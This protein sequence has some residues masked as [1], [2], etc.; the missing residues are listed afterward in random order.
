MTNASSAWPILADTLP[1]FIDSTPLLRDAA[2]LHERVAR[3]GYLYFKGLLPVEVVMQLRAEML[4]VLGAANWLADGAGR[5]DGRLNMEA[6]DAAPAETMRLDIGVTHDLYH[7]TQKLESLHALP[8]HPVLLRL[9]ETL[10]GGEVLVHPRHIARMVTPHHGMTPT[11][12]HQDFPLIQGTVNTWTCWMPLGGCPRAL[13]GLAVLRGSHRKGYIPTEPWAGAG[14]IATQLC[15]GE[16]EWL[17][18]DYEA[19][20]VLTFPSHTVHCGSKGWIRDEIRLSMDVRYQPAHEPIEANS[21]LP[22]C[23]L[24]WPEIYTGWRSDRFQYYWKKQ[25]V[26]ITPWDD[27][28]SKPERRIC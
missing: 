11:P 25:N 18:A 6:V 22:H 12:P 9:Y 14:G 23:T 15:P 8:H 24:G 28:Y 5:L 2:A 20:D 27:S 21:L 19:G 17:T 13:G 10:Y 7:Q 3:E 16:T 1:N 4:G 26:E